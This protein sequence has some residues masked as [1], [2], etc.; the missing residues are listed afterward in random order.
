MLR[1]SA[2]S[3]L[4]AAS[5]AGCDKP[6]PQPEADA[7][8]AKKAIEKSTE[9]YES[10]PY[11]QQPIAMHQ[12]V[13]KGLPDISAATCG[14]C[15]TEIYE[16]WKISTHARAWMDDA[17]FQE[18]LKKSRGN[19]PDQDVEWMCV[20]C[21][22]PVMNQLPKLVVGLN[23]GKLNSPQ[24]VE[25]PHYDEKLQLEAITCATCHV[26]DGKILGPWGDQSRA[27]HPVQKAESLLT[28]ENCV[29]CHQAEAVFPELTL[30]CFFTTGAEWKDS[31]A[32]KAGQTCQSCHM[33]EVERP[34]AIQDGLPVRKTR[35]H[36]FGG[37]LIPKH[38]K[39]E[40]EIAPLRKIYGSGVEFELRQTERKC[41][42]FDPCV[43]VELEILNNKA[44]HHMPTGDP[45]RHLVV[46][47]NAEGL[48]A[49]YVLQIGSKY[50]WWPEIKKLSDNRIP[51]GK[52]QITTHEFPAGTSKI[53]VKAEKFRMYQDAFD[54]HHLEGRY[55]R[56]RLFHESAWELAPEGAKRT[57]LRDDTTPEEPAKGEE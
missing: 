51:A 39:F 57:L 17:Q 19:G 56:G 27:P 12:E 3:L 15:H 18:E 26:R 35:R 5:L 23:D 49:P 43:W 40:A 54:H 20:N 37:S 24:Y 10:R 21:H 52:S 47:I 33:P 11:F 44:G 38:P 2:T 41:E 45:E 50:Q 25:N 29:R 46:Q 34:V 53:E 7:D 22:T 9:F 8:D 48:E 14:S 16:E 6:T 32:A 13:P 30:G 42:K 4:F 28:E 31:P 55:V 36:W 1:K